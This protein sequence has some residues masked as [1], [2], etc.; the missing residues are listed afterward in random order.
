MCAA[1]F[2]RNDVSV[3]GSVIQMFNHGV[4]IIGFVAGR[5]SSNVKQVSSR[6]PNWGGIAT[7]APVMTIMLVVVLAN[8]ALG[9]LMNTFPVNSDVLRIIPV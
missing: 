4:N 5:R 1:I 8:I 9:P 7:K 2:V 6:Y 3:Q